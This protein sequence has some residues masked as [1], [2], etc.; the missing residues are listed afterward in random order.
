VSFIDSGPCFCCWV[1]EL[2]NCTVKW[3]FPIR[4]ASAHFFRFSAISATFLPEDFLRSYEKRPPVRHCALHRAV[5]INGPNGN[6]KLYTSDGVE[7]LGRWQQP[8]ACW[9]DRD[10]N[11]H[12]WA[13]FLT[14]LVMLARQNKC[15]LPLR[16]A[17]QRANPT[18][19]DDVMA[20][21]YSVRL[22]LSGIQGVLVKIRREELRTKIKNSGLNEADEEDI[23]DDDDFYDFD[24]DDGD[25]DEMSFYETVF[26]RMMLLA[27]P[28]GPAAAAK[29]PEPHSRRKGALIPTA[30]YRARG[31]SRITSTSRHLQ[32]QQQQ[33]V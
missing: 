2:S 3:H 28:A 6:Q 4:L 14:A 7:L 1:L 25:E 30:G 32:H 18:T 19:R 10:S 8:V 31:A 9:P 13:G 12:F 22:A 27:A 33:E 23:D 5:I 17:L 29:D 11:C 15:Q 21:T 24:D 20:L 26:L 16:K